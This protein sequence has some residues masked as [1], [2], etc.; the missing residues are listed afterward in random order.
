MSSTPAIL[1]QM[2]QS[3]RN[4]SQSFHQ[5]SEICLISF[6]DIGTPRQAVRAAILAFFPLTPERVDYLIE[7][8][9]APNLNPQARPYFDRKATKTLLL[10]CVHAI[11]ARAAQWRGAS[12]VCTRAVYLE[13]R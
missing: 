7:H 5:Y 2:K 3:R 8:N 10:A 11:A 12:A 1:T 4:L 13:D 9:I 6:D